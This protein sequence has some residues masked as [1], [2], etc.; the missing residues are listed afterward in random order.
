MSPD[1]D[2]EKTHHRSFRGVSFLFTSASQFAVMERS[3]MPPNRPSHTCGVSRE[4]TTL[5]PTEPSWSETADRRW[6]LGA[7]R[8]PH[9]RRAWPHFSP[10]VPT[11]QVRERGF[12]YDSGAGAVGGISCPFVCTPLSAPQCSPPPQQLLPGKPGD[13]TPLERMAV[14]GGGL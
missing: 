1:S 5:R 10:E 12:W 2:R 6:G 11:G 13:R 8:K 7:L 14:A 4:L 3:L 9:P